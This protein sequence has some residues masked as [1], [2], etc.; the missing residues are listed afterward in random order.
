[1]NI[2][3]IL[4]ICWITGYIDPSPCWSEGNIC[5]RRFTRVMRWPPLPYSYSAAWFAAP[6]LWHPFLLVIEFDTACL[7]PTR[8]SMH[9]MWTTL[10]RD[11]IQW[12]CNVVKCLTKFVAKRHIQISVLG[13]PGTSFRLLSLVT[14]FKEFVFTIWLRLTYA[15]QIYPT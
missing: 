13:I 9:I 14:G 2:W 15:S 6:F 12:D 1:M 3:K 10:E 8:P 11:R 5:S 4:I 7:T